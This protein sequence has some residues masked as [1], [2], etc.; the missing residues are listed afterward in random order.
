M[1]SPLTIGGMD[2]NTARTENM[3]RLVIEAGGPAEW[4]RRYGRARWQQAQVSQWISEA[5]PKGIGRNLARDLE[6]AMGLSSGELDRPPSSASQDPRLERAIV[7]AAVKLVRELDA[8]SPQPP[9]PETY[10]TR[11]YIAMLVAREEG[12]SGILEGQDLVGALRRF[13]AELRKAG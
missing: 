13:A 6:A 10:S 12:A 2:A 1:V 4:A 5:K 7:E 3:R 9:S 8:M 11:L